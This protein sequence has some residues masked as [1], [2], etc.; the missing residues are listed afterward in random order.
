MEIS[1]NISYSKDSNTSYL[2]EVS[3]HECGLDNYHYIIEFGVLRFC[4]LSCL[5]QHM[6]SIGAIKVAYIDTEEEQI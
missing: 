5:S 4:D 1:D 6:L 3:C 2:M